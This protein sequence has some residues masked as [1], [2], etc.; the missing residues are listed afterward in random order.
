MLPPTQ[1]GLRGASCWSSFTGMCLNLI[2]KL[3]FVSIAIAAGFIV[4]LL[5]LELMLRFLPVETNVEYAVVTK[6]SPYL[7]VQPHS[8]RISSLGWNFYSVVT[9][10]ANNY[11]YYSDVDYS[12]NGKPTLA[13]IGDS[14]VEAGKVAKKRSLSEIL[15]N[16]DVDGI[17]SVGIAGSALSQYIAFVK[18]AESEFNPKAFVIVVVGNDFDESLCSVRPLPGHHCYERLDGDLKLTLRE[19]YPVTGIRR[20]ARHSALMRYLV[21]NLN[22]DWRR[23]VSA[24]NLLSDEVTDVRY[25]GNTDFSKTIPIEQESLAMVDQFFKDLGVIIGSKPVLFVV[26]A[27]RESVYRGS[28]IDSSFFSKM[29]TYFITRAHDH[30]H[31]VVDMYPIFLKHYGDHREKFEFPTDGHWNELG[32][33]LAAEA[34]LRS[35]TVQQVMLSK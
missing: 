11:G 18:L 32:H 23:L 28:S 2:K 29:R 5:L 20:V 22:V 7:H 14:Y 31:E 34:V 16:S 3:T 33:R 4:P 8:V 12:K 19:S 15:E 30:N 9:K 26:D 25:A 6:S 24:A 1:E 13:V 10:E 35:K 17:Y 27:D 21:F